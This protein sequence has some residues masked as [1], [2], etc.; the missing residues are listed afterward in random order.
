[1][2]AQEE[3]GRIGF[4]RL[5]RWL[6]KMDR[7]LGPQGLPRPAVGPFPYAHKTV[8]EIDEERARRAMLRSLGKD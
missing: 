4:A 1:M 8:A 3:V 7:E 5:D 6:A 2:S